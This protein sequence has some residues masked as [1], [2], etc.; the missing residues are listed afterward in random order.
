MSDILSR[1]PFIPVRGLIKRFVNCTIFGRQ[2]VTVWAP[3]T[4][5]NRIQHTQQQTER[6]REV[7][8]ENGLLDAFGDRSNFIACRLDSV[9]DSQI[10]TQCG[11]VSSKGNRGS[12]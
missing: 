3:E 10:A 2:P 1:E 5:S 11:Q 4:A 9:N 8:S 7:I 6:K 12:F